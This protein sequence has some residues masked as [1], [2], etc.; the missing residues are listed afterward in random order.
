MAPL[1]PTSPLPHCGMLFWFPY[2]WY[3]ILNLCIFGVR[4]RAVGIAHSC[5][6]EGPRSHQKHRLDMSRL[7]ST[8]GAQQRPLTPEGHKGLG[9]GRY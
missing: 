2:S 6:D 8:G 5:G 3:K 7:L 4:G 1:I 9:E